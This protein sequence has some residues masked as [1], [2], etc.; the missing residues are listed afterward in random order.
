MFHQN[1]CFFVHAFFCCCDVYSDFCECVFLLKKR[2]LSF[3][4]VLLRRN[5]R[6]IT[7]FFLVFFFFL[8]PTPLFFF[9]SP[10]FLTPLL[11][12]SWLHF[13]LF[14]LVHLLSFAL[15][16]FFM[17]SLSPLFCSILRNFRWS[18]LKKEWIDENFLFKAKSKTY[19]N[20]L[21]LSQN[22]NAKEK[23]A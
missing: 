13:S 2:F 5:Y 18:T 7:C 6:A 1:P 23:N 21:T 9:L 19:S 20:F 22:L 3:R 15:I 11:F 17:T 8:I 4:V 12:A 14:T 16:H 10:L